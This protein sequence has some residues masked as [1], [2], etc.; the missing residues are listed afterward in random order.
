MVE[1]QKWSRVTRQ[2]RRT[3]AAAYIRRLS[4]DR[5]TQWHSLISAPASVVIFRRQGRSTVDERAVETRETAPGVLPQSGSGTVQCRG[6]ELTAQMTAGADPVITGG[7]RDAAAAFARLRT[8]MITTTISS[9]RTAARRVHGKDQR[10]MHMVVQRR[11]PRHRRA[12]AKVVATLG[13]P[14]VGQ[15][16]QL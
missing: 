4:S 10:K 7:S 15:R 14:L 13:R 16:V 5:G 1:L 8:A 12:K 3:A 9:T 2:C 11:L 6:V